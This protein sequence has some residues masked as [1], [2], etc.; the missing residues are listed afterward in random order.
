MSTILTLMTD[1]LK[2]HQAG[3]LPQAERI[4]RE[5]LLLDPNQG[6]ALNLLG[7]LA[8]QMGQPETAI[9]LLSRAV[10]AHPHEPEF[11]S[12]LAAAYTAT[13]D[14]ASAIT[15]YRKAVRLKPQAVGSRAHLC[16]A[17]LEQGQQDE[18]LALCLEALRLDRDSALAWCVLGELV[19]H[20]CHTFTDADIAHL[21]QLVADG[22]LPIHDASMIHFTLA[23]HRE[24]C[25][26]YDEAFRSYQ[27]A[28]E[29][30]REVYRQSKQRFDPGMHLDLIDRLIAFFTPEFFQRIEAFG[31]DSELP[32]FVVGMVRSGTSLVEQILASLPRVFGAGELKDI[33]QLS[34]A[35]PQHLNVAEAYPPCLA[36]I[37]PAIARKLAYGYLLRLAGPCGASLRMIDKMPHN[38]LHLGLIAVLFP[39]ARIVHCRRDPMDVCTA[40]YFQNFKWLPYTASLDDIVFYYRQYERLMEHWKRVLPLRMHEVVYEQM[41]ANQEAVS[42]ELVSFCGLP[43]DERC[44]AFYQSRRTVQT[45]SKLQVRQPIYTRS[46]A[47]WQHFA[48][49]LGPLRQALQGPAPPAQS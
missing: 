2:F 13:G 11:H 31:A 41:V 45:A 14:V 48:A 39:R 44:L 23:A 9:D 47:R 30:K 25:G 24:K 40:A 4:Y 12:T 27:K 16:D 3:D 28:N 38:Y 29:L 32:V 35:L 1:A 15:H 18:A 10:A 8:N 7:V 42:R 43:W 21:Q 20:G 49:H 19:G 17:L 26:A 5:V 46:V 33:D 22:R 34:T 37:D 36:H 6:D